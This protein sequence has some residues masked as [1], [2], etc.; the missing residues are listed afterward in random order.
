MAAYVPGGFE[1]DAQPGEGPL[2]QHLPVVAGIAPRDPDG[3]GLAVGA[4]VVPRRGEVAAGKAV[5]GEEVLRRAGRAVA[6]EVRGARAY[7]AAVRR[8]LARGERGILEVGDADRDVEAFLDE[9]HR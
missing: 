5:V 3:V 1:G 9:V 2:A 7:H 4:A 6:L 8:K